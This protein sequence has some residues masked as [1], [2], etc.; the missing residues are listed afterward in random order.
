MTRRASGILATVAMLLIAGGAAAQPAPA[1]SALAPPPSYAWTSQPSPA[2][3]PP[4]PPL[5]PLA[6]GPGTGMPNLALGYTFPYPPAKDE[7]AHAYS[8]YGWHILIGEI[9]SDLVTLISIGAQSTPILAF[10]VLGR[11]ASAPIIHLAHQ[12]PGRAAVSLAIESLVP[13]MALGAA[14]ILNN[15]HCPGVCKALSA[16]SITLV[17]VSMLVG[18][19]VDAAILGGEEAATPE[20]NSARLLLLPLTV[21]PLELRVPAAGGRRAFAE[22]PVGLAIGARF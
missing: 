20:V 12:H 7:R 3:A 4:P 22:A 8:W 21:A 11:A 16:A 6:A 14:L 19:V 15:S 2:A 9:S 13:G 1:A 17:P 10:G 18:T 5:V